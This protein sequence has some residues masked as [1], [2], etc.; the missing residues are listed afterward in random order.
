MYATVAE[1]NNTVM[2]VFSPAITTEAAPSTVGSKMWPT[3]HDVY[4]HDLN[5]T[6][7]NS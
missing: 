2:V 4:T 5:D 1:H 6:A 7:V 3:K